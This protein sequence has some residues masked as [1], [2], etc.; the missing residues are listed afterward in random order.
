M[1]GRLP[2]NEADGRDREGLGPGCTH[3]AGDGPLDPGLSPGCTAVPLCYS[4]L[5]RGTLGQSQNAASAQGRVP[6]LG[7][8]S[9]L[10][11][12]LIAVY[13]EGLGWR[14]SSTWSLVRV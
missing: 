12:Q 14:G 9:L 4:S 3:P 2:A 7:A 8:W 10:G 6:H 5:V 13:V 11:A 1:A